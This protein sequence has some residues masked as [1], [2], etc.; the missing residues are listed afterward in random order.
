MCPQ[1][2]GIPNVWSIA[3][4]PK[5]GAMRALI[6]HVCGHPPIATSMKRR[7]WPMAESVYSLYLKD[8]RGEIMKKKDCLR[9]NTVFCLVLVVLLALLLAGCGK[10]GSGKSLRTGTGPALQAQ[11]GGFGGCG[12]KSGPDVQEEQADEQKDSADGEE[13]TAPGGDQAPANAGDDS[14]LPAQTGTDPSADPDAAP[15]DLRTRTP[16]RNLQPI[17]ARNL[18]PGPL[19]LPGRT[20]RFHPSLPARM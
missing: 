1:C 11:A 4:A 16:L 3:G 12:K 7:F 5:R 15:A 20:W 13:N 19:L 8:C 18:R 9:R 17:P 14:D 6:I 2:G 10:T